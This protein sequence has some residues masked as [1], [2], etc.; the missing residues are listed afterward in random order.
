MS[1]LLNKDAFVAFS[2]VKPTSPDGVIVGKEGTMPR[3]SEADTFRRGYEPAI[4]EW[5]SFSG[6][7]Y[8]VYTDRGWV[9]VDTVNELDEELA[10]VRTVLYSAGEEL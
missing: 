1:F 10:E 2:L 7:Q 9:V 6:N 4:G 3:I 8:K 5:Y